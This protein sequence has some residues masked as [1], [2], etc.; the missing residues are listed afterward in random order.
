M[1]S[2]VTFSELK[3]V[4]WLSLH[5]PSV[6]RHGKRIAWLLAG[7]WQDSLSPSSPDWPLF[8]T[9]TSSLLPSK[10]TEDHVTNYVE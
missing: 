10:N 1:S 4:L 9:E 3:W 7:L 2:L 5:G 6:Q 8:S